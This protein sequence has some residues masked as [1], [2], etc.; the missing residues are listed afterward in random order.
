MSPD[1]PAQE[2]RAR[3]EALLSDARAA[4]L[5]ETAEDLLVLLEDTIVIRHTFLKV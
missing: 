4:G 2:L 5:A 1:D 3:L